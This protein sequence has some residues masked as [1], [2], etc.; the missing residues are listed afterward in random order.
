MSLERLS[1]ILTYLLDC[2]KKAF[3]EKE[4]YVWALLLALKNEQ[5]E[6]LRALF[7]LMGSGGKKRNLQMLLD[8]NM[9]TENLKN[10]F[11]RIEPSQV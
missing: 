1:S 8:Q 9:L 10:Y 7:A 4:R 6:D 3:T 11:A 2:L 5:K